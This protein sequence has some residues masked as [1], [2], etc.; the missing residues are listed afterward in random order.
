MSTL[1][2]KEKMQERDYQKKGST[3]KKF[4]TSFDR[5][6]KR[7]VRNQLKSAGAIDELFS[8][9]QDLNLNIGNFEQATPPVANIVKISG[10]LFFALIFIFLAFSFFEKDESAEI[11]QVKIGGWYAVK[12][13]NGESYYGEVDDTAA[14]PVVIKSVYYDYDYDQINGSSTSTEKKVEGANL[15]LV[16]RG[17]EAHG[18]NG[19][20]EIVR[21][22]VLLFEPLKED[23]KVLKAI[24]DYEK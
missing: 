24:L 22:Q 4:V 21:A 10:L 18:P 9:D 7:P 6:G 14:D 13:V 3:S 12:L 20:M 2:L 19:A 5:I 16:K 17:K 11:T 1:D 23:S 15:R 8:D